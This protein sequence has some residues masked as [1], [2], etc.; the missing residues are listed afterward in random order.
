MVFK[1]AVLAHHAA[2]QIKDGFKD[3][4]ITVSVC[5]II[6]FFFHHTQLNEQ[7]QESKKTPGHNIT[8]T[9]NSLKTSLLKE[10]QYSHKTI[11]QFKV[12]D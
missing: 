8:I 1:P 3:L 11:H 12:Y 4:F 6:T 9:V 7:K 10:I 5:F 2:H